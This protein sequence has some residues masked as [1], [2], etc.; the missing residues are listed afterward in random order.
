MTTATGTATQL[1]Q[2]YI[3][4]TQEEGDNTALECDPPRRRT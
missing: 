1:Y 2:L 3:K 4:A